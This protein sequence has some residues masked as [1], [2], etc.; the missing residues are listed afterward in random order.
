MINSLS[1]EKEMLLD[2]VAV[3]SLDDGWS[4]FIFQMKINIKIL[5]EEKNKTNKL[6]LNLNYLQ[7]EHIYF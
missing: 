5:S 6:I 2:G 7:K 3:R 1:E 4:H